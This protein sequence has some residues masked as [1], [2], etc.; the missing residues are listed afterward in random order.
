MLENESKMEIFKD[1]PGY[2]YYQISNLGRV[3][4]AKTQRYLKASKNNNG[5]YQINL[6]AIN[7]KRKKE[8]IHRLV[9]IVFIPNPDKLPEVEHKDRNRANNNVENL[10]WVSRSTNCR[11]TS[12]NRKVRVYKN[13]ELIKECCLTEASEII[14]CARGSIYSY[15]RRNQK[16]IN[17]IYRLEII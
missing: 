13:E 10:C 17:K 11:N 7:G 1:I 5:Y 14:G 8:L 3:W 16:Y 6:I 9:A 15:L 4:N 2:P 12:Q